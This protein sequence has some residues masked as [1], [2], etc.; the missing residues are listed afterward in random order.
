MKKLKLNL[1]E[2]KVETFEMDSLKS[3]NSG[4]VIA[5]NVTPATSPAAGCPTW[6]ISCET[7]QCGISCQGTCCLNGNSG[8]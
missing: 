3:K 8:C 1:D 2:I 5:Q 4:T 6:A 7:M